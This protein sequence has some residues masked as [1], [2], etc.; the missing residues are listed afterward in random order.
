MGATPAQLSEMWQ[1][2]RAILVIGK[3]DRVILR[4]I[5]GTPSR[6]RMAISWVSQ[7]SYR[8]VVRRATLKRPIVVTSRHAPKGWGQYLEGLSVADAVIGELKRGAEVIRLR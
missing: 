3:P 7:I 5:C 6:Q 4:T 8:I 2:A 1:T